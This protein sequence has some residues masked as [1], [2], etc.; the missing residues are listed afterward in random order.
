MEVVSSIETPGTSRRKRRLCI[1]EGLNNDQLHCDKLYGV[2]DSW[3]DV[4][5]SVFLKLNTKPEVT[6][7]MTHYY[8]GCVFK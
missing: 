7:Y 5:F 4:N 1:P 8:Y 3:Y 2:S 6:I